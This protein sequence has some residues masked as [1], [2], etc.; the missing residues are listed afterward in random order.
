M[1]NADKFKSELL[2]IKKRAFRDA[3]QKCSKEWGLKYPP[4]V[5]ITENPCPSSSS[6]TIAHIHLDE[7]IICIWER[8][9]ESL[10]LD[11]IEKTAAHEVAHLVSP[12][13]NGIHAKAQGELQTA[14]W[15]PPPGVTVINGGGRKS[16]KR[17]TKPRKVRL[18]NV[19]SYHLCMKRTELSTCKYC[20]KKFCS[21]HLNP[22][23]PTLPYGNKP[24]SRDEWVGLGHPCPDYPAYLEQKE[25]ERRE[26]AKET[27]D[28]MA[29]RP[30]VPQPIEREKYIPRE[31]PKPI[32]YESTP[33]KKRNL[34]I[35]TGDIAIVIVALILIIILLMASRL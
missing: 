16:S 34:R 7:R 12:F 15:H 23:V 30:S 17:L 22:K 6:D 24:W 5:S 32:I 11:T 1:K 3:V 28:K 29:K 18:Q 31:I 25:K 8:K 13:H 27:L 26:K 33:P 10:D 14:I 20:G 21:E 9:L 35:D 19:C 2:E 4:T